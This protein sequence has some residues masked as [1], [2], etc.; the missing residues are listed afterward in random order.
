MDGV[1]NVFDPPGWQFEESLLA[2][3]ATVVAGLD[4]VGRG[5]I[6]GPVA[7][8]AV[9][10]DPVRRPAWAEDLR[11]SKLLT[12]PARERLAA[13]IQREAVAAAV[14]AASQR[15]I[16]EIGI[17]PASRLAMLRAL[18]ALRVRPSHLIIDAFRLPE[19]DLP[20]EAVV[21]GDRLSVSVAAA[22]ILAKVARDGW[23][24]RLDAAYPGY[25]FAAHKGYAS[26]EHIEAVRQLGYC[27]AH[28]RSFTLR[29]L[30]EPRLPGFDAVSV[31]S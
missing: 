23:M 2:T 3:G 31:A 9:V 30:L 26:P 8:A 28:R 24:Q 22:S 4:E 20:Q 5:P 18:D 14:G 27:P 13:L 21:H 16:D 10:L 11:D 6:A 1:E 25:G 17:A 19:V 15:E 12:K 29:P 7:A